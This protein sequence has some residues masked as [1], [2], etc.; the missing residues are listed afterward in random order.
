M[1]DRM[2]Y[3]ILSSLKKQGYGDGISRL[4]ELIERISSINP[5]AIEIKSLHNINSNSIFLIGKLDW[6][7]NDENKP[8]MSCLSDFVNSICTDSTAYAGSILQQAWKLFSICVFTT[9]DER[10]VQSASL[11]ES[12]LRLACINYCTNGDIFYCNEG[13]KLLFFQNTKKFNSR[14]EE[15]IAKSSLSEVFESISQHCKNCECLDSNTDVYPCFDV[16]R[17]IL[18]KGSLLKSIFIDS[19]NKN[20]NWGWW[21]RGDLNCFLKENGNKVFLIKNLSNIQRLNSKDFEIIEKTRNALA[22]GNFKMPNEDDDI[23]NKEETIIKRI[24]DMLVSVYMFMYRLTTFK[25]EFVDVGD[26]EKY[27]IGKDLIKYICDISTYL[28][29]EIKFYPSKK[30]YKQ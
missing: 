11:I 8:L 26:E 25:G 20:L 23:Y 9:I 10:F 14:R 3:K 12:C 1:S 21:K 16:L 30:L 15:D 13:F 27:L 4:S 17:S 19:E 2:K 22:H 24:C 5:S 7:N 6:N 18:G 28:D 29:S